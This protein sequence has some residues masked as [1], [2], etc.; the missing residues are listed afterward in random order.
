MV[1][2][3]VDNMSFALHFVDIASNVES[4][5]GTY[6]HALHGAWPGSLL[7]RSGS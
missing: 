7:A 3:V 4:T 1:V 5:A 2:L 6:A